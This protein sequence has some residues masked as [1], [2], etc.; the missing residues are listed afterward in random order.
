M[1]CRAPC[2]RWYNGI[3]QV[4]DC[5]AWIDVPGVGEV[6][7]VTGRVVDPVVR[8]DEMEAADL[9]CRKAYAIGHDFHNFVSAVVDALDAVFWEAPHQI[10]Q[11]GG[12]DCSYNCLL[13]L[14]LEY[15][16]AYVLLSN[17]MEALDGF[18]TLE[19]D[20]LI[21]QW[22]KVISN[23]T[24]EVTEEDRS[25]MKAAIKGNNYGLVEDAFMIDCWDCYRARN[26]QAAAT[27]GILNDD[28]DCTC[29]GEEAPWLELDW[30]E[31]FDLT[32]ISDPYSSITYGTF[33]QGLGFVSQSYG[34]GQ[35]WGAQ[36]DPEHT[37][38]GSTT[39]EYMRIEVTG[40]WAWPEGGTRHLLQAVGGSAEIDLDDVSGGVGEWEGTDIIPA[41]TFA[42]QHNVV[43]GDFDVHQTITRIIVGGSGVNPFS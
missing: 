7:D 41:D 43:V 27:A 10:E 2:I 6:P 37:G 21:C 29:P 1:N 9:A 34:G 24:T 3:L 30:Y 16:I 4:F 23:D 33:I 26:M 14:V 42:L 39:L 31:E 12:W 5:G 25:E 32:T 20:R 22:A 13:N 35:L 28:A 17:F 18:S 40:N 38:G 19:R 15:Q 36:L 11:A 8:P